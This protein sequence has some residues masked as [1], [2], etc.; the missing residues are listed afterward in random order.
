[1]QLFNL[2]SAFMK[3]NQQQFIQHVFVLK[4]IKFRLFYKYGTIF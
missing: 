2:K 4:L 3:E 1:M